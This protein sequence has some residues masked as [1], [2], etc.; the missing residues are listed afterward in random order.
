MTKLDEAAMMYKALQRLVIYKRGEWLE[1][2]NFA[3]RMSED[4]L[5]EIENETMRIGGGPL[6]FDG[7]TKLFGI[8]I[9]GEQEKEGTLELWEKLMPRM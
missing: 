3:W 5:L 6:P 7:L 1:P 8:P 2:T 9:E 4:V